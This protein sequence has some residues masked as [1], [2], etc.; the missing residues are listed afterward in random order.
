MPLQKKLYKISQF[1]LVEV[2]CA[3][4]PGETRDENATLGVILSHDPWCGITFFFLHSLS[5]FKLFSLLLVYSI[6]P[7]FDPSCSG[8]GQLSFWWTNRDPSHLTQYCF[9]YVMGIKKEEV[10]KCIQNSWL[11]I[12]RWELMVLFFPYYW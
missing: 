9:N 10:I 4:W 12:R 6:T 7:N 11:Q 1:F 5:F 8:F 2:T 3:V